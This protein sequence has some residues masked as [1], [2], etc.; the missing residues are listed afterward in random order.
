MPSQILQFKSN[1]PR[2]TRGFVFLGILNINQI[3][4]E[5]S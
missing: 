1:Q 5:I 2:T 3:V 4:N